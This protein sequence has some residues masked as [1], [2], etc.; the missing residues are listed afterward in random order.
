MEIS[1]A[2]L[3]DDPTW[4]AVR[5][6]DLS[7]DNEEDGMPLDKPAAPPLLPP[8]L[9]KVWKKKADTM[10]EDT[11]NSDAEPTDKEVA[12][13]VAAALTEPPAEA[14]EPGKNDKKKAWPLGF[15]PL[16]AMPDRDRPGERKGTTAAPIEREAHFGG[17]RNWFGAGSRSP[18]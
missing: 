9:M 14:A 1:G 13:E 16:Q 6:E 4:N 2:F 10:P 12:E 11:S 7:E 5:E 8:E 17:A 3:A 18:G 15:S